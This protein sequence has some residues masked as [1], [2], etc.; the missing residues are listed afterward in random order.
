[1]GPY[2]IKTLGLAI[3]AGKHQVI[4][5]LDLT[6]ARE[7]CLVFL[8][9]NKSGKTTLL[10][11]LS[12]KILPDQGSLIIQGREYKSISSNLLPG[13]EL[14]PQENPMNREKTLAE[15][16]NTKTDSLKLSD[17]QKKELVNNS[18]DFFNLH[19]DTTTSLKKLSPEKQNKA[20]IAL[21]LLSRP[22]IL[23]IDQPTQG[24]SAEAKKKLWPLLNKLKGKLTLILAT[25]DWEEAFILAD[26][27]ALLSQGKLL[28]LGTPA[29]IKRDLFSIET[30]EVKSDFIPENVL[31]AMVDRFPR[32]IETTE[33]VEIMGD[34]LKI[35]EI[36]EFF[37]EHGVKVKEI[38]IKQP[39]LEALF[40]RLR[41]KER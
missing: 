9:T 34:E 12:G 10:K 6:I 30:F 4:K 23:L 16:F 25:S 38:N 11:A 39:S 22:E 5:N 2:A 35:E 40:Q 41:L 28:A 27:I 29:E 21:A 24:L 17:H 32:V 33:G 8:G 20:S 18:L 14:V 13:I 3:K 36:E 31:K 26:R 15:L 37:Q 7:E 19:H 1:M